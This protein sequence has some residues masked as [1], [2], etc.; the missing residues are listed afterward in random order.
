[1][2]SHG[3]EVICSMCKIKKRNYAYGMC[4]KCYRT[5]D[6][7][8]SIHRKAVIKYSAK[9]REEI[10]KRSCKRQKEDRI[11]NPEKYRILYKKIY[12]I[13]L[14]KYGQSGM[15]QFYDK[16]K[17]KAYRLKYRLNNKQKIKKQLAKLRGNDDTKAKYAK[18]AKEWRGNNIEIL[19]KQ[20]KIY[21]KYKVVLPLEILRN[22]V[23]RNESI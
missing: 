8:K 19:K 5:T 18:K 17:F 16:E 7:W 11:N 13:R 1:M 2:T 20:H 10:N 3:I 15:R 21:G 22:E 9:N 4:D 14:K 23:V 12:A 6:R